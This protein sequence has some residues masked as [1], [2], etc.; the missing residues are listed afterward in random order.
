MISID[1]YN[2]WKHEKK[3]YSQCDLEKKKIAHPPSPPEKQLVAA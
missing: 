1:T 2:I 3:K